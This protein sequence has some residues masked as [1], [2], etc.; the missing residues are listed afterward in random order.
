MTDMSEPI[1]EAQSPPPG[2]VTGEEATMRDEATG[3]LPSD[4]PRGY[5]HRSDGTVVNQD[6]EVVGRW[7]YIPEGSPDWPTPEEEVMYFVESA[8]I[9]YE[10]GALD[11]VEMRQWIADGLPEGYRIGED[12]EIA[13]DDP[14]APPVPRLGDLAPLP[15]SEA[16][17]PGK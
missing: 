6:D 9:H 1:T 4:R 13:S 2:A 14:A 3:P 7:S 15:Q 16:G 5:R 8:R 11:A 17:Q 10:R 12:G